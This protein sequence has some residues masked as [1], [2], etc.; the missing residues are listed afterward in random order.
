MS[1]GQRAPK[2]VSEGPK[3]WERAKHNA[4]LRP[5]TKAAKLYLQRQDVAAQV[6]EAVGPTSGFVVTRMDGA[7][8]DP[9]AV[10]RR[11]LN[12]C[13]TSCAALQLQLETND[14]V[15][16]GVI[17]SVLRAAHATHH[18]VQHDMG[19][20]GRTV[21]RLARAELR[22]P[23][24]CRVC[25]TRIQPTRAVDKVAVA[26]IAA[27]TA[28]TEA[29]QRWYVTPDGRMFAAAELRVIEV[30]EGESVILTEYSTNELRA[31]FAKDFGY[32]L[33]EA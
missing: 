5:K 15:A 9:H 31:V 26:H 32:P 33:A 19:M 2:D 6:L 23:V 24:T 25:G 12:T 10:R 13:S 11:R 3:R 18:S 30:T 17:V 28:A 14:K 8:N 16:T 21:S 20:R 1:V 22:R 29:K 4:L 27:A 7:F